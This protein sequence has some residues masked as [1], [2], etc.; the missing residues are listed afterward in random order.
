MVNSDITN[1][2]KIQFNTKLLYWF[3]ENKR[4]LPWRM[5]REPYRIWL[6]EVMLQQT[7]VEQVLPYYQ[8]FLETFP[9]IHTLAWASVS[10]VLKVWEGLGYYARARNLLMAAQEMV[11]KYQGKIPENYK[12]LS[13][14]PGLGP[15]TTAAVLSIA[16]N[17]DYAVV[18]GNVTR[19]LCRIFKIE[20]D[21]KQNSTKK[22]LSRL[23]SNLLPSGRAGAFNQAM[24]ELGAVICTPQKPHCDICPVNTLCKART[25]TDPSSLPIKIP[26]PPKPHYDVTAGIIWNDG[27]ILITQRP[28][29]GLLGGLWE[30]PGGKQEQG[31]SLEECLVREI[32]EELAIQISVDRP[33]MTV[34][35][36]Y[37]HFR[38]TLH[39]FHCTYLGGEPRT[40]ECSALRW[41]R[42]DELPRFAFPKADQKLLEALLAPPV[43]PDFKSG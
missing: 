15:Y 28:A 30:F 41:V 25:L 10:E 6:S 35:H 3:E 38:I 24:M 34:K 14:L 43:H 22:K 36:A 4:P 7:Q 42:P 18:D 16:F 40:I 1:D 2:F 5:T 8:R 29:K 33:F 31:E 39:A 37:T 26:R 20:Q 23:A 32:Q 19:V 17:Q 12:E 21:P 27:R 9:D 13:Q 11:Q